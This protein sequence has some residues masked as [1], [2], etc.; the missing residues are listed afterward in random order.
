[1]LLIVFIRINE[2]YTQD[3][4]LLI[5]PDCT[6]KYIGGG[7]NL[8]IEIVKEIYKNLN[9]KSVIIGSSDTY[10]VRRL[11]SEKIPFI[12]VDGKTVNNN[13]S[14]CSEDTVVL[15]HYYDGLEKIK[16]LKCRVIIWGIL[17]QQ[18]TGWNRFGFERRITG[19]KYI[20]DCFTRKFIRKMCNLGG[21]VSMDGTT[22]DAFESFVGHSLNLPI[23]PVPVRVNHS[24]LEKRNGTVK[25]N[26]LCVSYIGRSDDIWKIKPVK[27]FISDLSTITNC[28]FTVSIYTSKSEPFERELASVLASNINLRF[29]FGLF[30]EE[31]RNHLA[32]NSDLHFSMGTSALEGAIVNLPT[33]LID[34]CME[35][36]PVNYKYKWLHES[37]RCSLGRFIDTNE[38]EFIGA[39]IKEVV[40]SCLSTGKRDLIANKC[41]THVMENHLTS[42]VVD[43]LLNV[44]SQA[45]MK[46]VA[47]N[48][49]ATWG[50]AGMLKNLK[51]A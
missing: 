26:A 1:M 41:F 21:L 47:R 23:V 44:K 30:G 15:F 4:K 42:A 5:F 11:V 37:D 34:P 49:P 6:Y 3:Y 50:I 10:M 14:V 35:D 24:N 2:N 27:K 8:I 36:F 40:E 43:K 7:Q 38:T 29:H 32:L 22:A 9:E 17:A 39:T 46:D 12:F 25:P 18:I 51:W 20:G 13:L 48:T 45:R 19:K 33:I 16:H 28:E 31:L